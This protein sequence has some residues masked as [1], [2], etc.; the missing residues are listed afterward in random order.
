MLHVFTSLLL[1]FFK[2]TVQSLG[3]VELVD[4]EV[5]GNQRVTPHMFLLNQ[6]SHTGF[7]LVSI[8]K[9]PG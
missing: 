5:S 7:V 2:T 6:D 4:K 3:L 8:P 1:L 9:S